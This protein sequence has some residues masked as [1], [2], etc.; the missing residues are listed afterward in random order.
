MSH[1]PVSR[2]PVALRFAE[3]RH[4]DHLVSGVRFGAAERC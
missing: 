4:S 2:M 1:F 3:N